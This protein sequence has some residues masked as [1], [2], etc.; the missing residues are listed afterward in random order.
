MTLGHCGRTMEH[1]DRRVDHCDWIMEYY[2]GTVG[3][4]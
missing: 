2:D 1:G 3:T 4:L